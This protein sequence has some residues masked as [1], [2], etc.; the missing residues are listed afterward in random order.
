MKRHVYL[1]SPNGELVEAYIAH[2][3]HALLLE[4]LGF[5]QMETKPL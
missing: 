5:V 2:E 4:Q 1:L 3:E